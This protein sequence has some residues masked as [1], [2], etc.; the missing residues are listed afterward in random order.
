MFGENV[1]I[2]NI[3]KTINFNDVIVRRIN[4]GTE[5]SIVKL[6]LPYKIEKAEITDAL[7]NSISQVKLN[8]N[9]IEF[10]LIPK[11]ITNI[12]LSKGNN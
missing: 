8:K 4:N 5:T 6:E 10:E 1:N 2:L 12:K 11:K 7:E 3:Q 9:I